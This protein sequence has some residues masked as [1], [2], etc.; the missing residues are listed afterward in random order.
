MKILLRVEHP[1]AT[2]ERVGDVEVDVA[3]THTIAELA[4][5]LASACRA[6]HLADRPPLHQQTMRLLLPEA[7]IADSGIVSGDTIALGVGLP[8]DRR[9]HELRSA[10]SDGTSHPQSTFCTGA[11]SATSGA[12]A[13]PDPVPSSDG[14]ADDLHLVVTSGVDAGL[15]YPL[16]P[17][18]HTVGRS[19]HCELTLVDPQVSRRDFRFRVTSGLG[20]DPGDGNRAD[21]SRAERGRADASGTDRVRADEGGAEGVGAGARRGSPPGNRPADVMPPPSTTPPAHPQPPP[22]DPH[23]RENRRWA[24]LAPVAVLEPGGERSNELRL[25]GHPVTEPAPLRPGDDLQVGCT[26]LQIR[27]AITERR[28]V[29][30]ATSGT[31]AFERTPQFRQP[32]QVRQLGALG[33]VPTKPSPRRFQLLAVLAPLLMG[34]SMAFFFDSPRFLLFAVLSPVV[35]IGNTIDSRRNGAKDHERKVAELRARIETRR[36]ELRAHLADEREL[37]HRAA[38]DVMELAHQA[39]THDKRLWNRARRSPD[40]L[41]LRVGLGTVTPELDIKAEGQGD[42]DL[43]LEIADAVAEFDRLVDVPVTVHLPEAGVVGAVGATTETARFAGGLAL[44]AACLHSPEDLVI[45]SAIPHERGVNEWLKWLPHTRSK[46]SPIGEAHLAGDPDAAATLIRAVSRVAETRSMIADQKLD[47]R[48]PWVLLLVDRSLEPDPAI[49]ARLLDLGASVGVSV[50]W[51]AESDRFVPRQAEVVARLRTPGEGVP[52]SLSYVDP[53]RDAQEF[54]PVRVGTAVAERTARALAPLV[55]ATATNAAATVP[56]MVTLF[57]ALGVERIDPDWI[58]EQWLT[59]RGYALPTPVGL[60]DAGPL[61]LDLVRHG[62]HGLIGGTSGAGKSELVQSLVANLIALNSPERVNLLFID[63]KGGALSGLF[64]D[65]PHA[66]GAVTNLDAMLSLRA[67][68]SLK[69]ELD[70][71]MAL[72]EQKRVKDIAE[73]L[74]RHPAEAPASLVIVVDEFAS[75][76]RELPEFVEGIVSIAERGRSLG[77]HLLLSTQR[78]SGSIN[79]NIQQN[80]NLRMSLRML[81]AGESNNVIGTA[82]AA[83]IPGHLKGRGYARLGPGELIAFQSSWSGAPLGGEDGLRPIVVAPFTTLPETAASIPPMVAVGPSAPVDD[84]PGCSGSVTPGRAG[85]NATELDAVLD[86]VVEAASRLGMG[87]GRAPWLETLPNLVPLDT[88]LADPRSAAVS[89][90]SVT[91]GMVD[92]PEAQDQYPANIDLDDGGGLAVYGSGGSGKTTTLLT[93]VCS[94]A[95]RDSQAGG[96]QLTIFGIDFASRQLG[97]LQQLPQCE[98][99]ANGDDLE[100]VTRIIATVTRLFAERQAVAADAAARNEPA[101][102]ETPVLLVI[103]G[104]DA[105][106]ETFSSAGNV[107]ALLPWFDRIVNLITQGRQVGIHCLLATGSQSGPSA[108]LMNTISNRITLR[109]TDDTAYRSFGVPSAIAT[110]LEL[111][112]GQALTRTGTGLQIAVVGH[113]PGPDGESIVDPAAVGELADG[114]VGSVLPAC[115]TRPLPTEVTRPAS[116]TGA[117]SL[118]RVELG[119][120]DLSLEPVAVDL[121]INTLCVLGPPRSGRSTSLLNAGVQLAAAGAEV[122]AFGPHGSRLDR[123]HAWS[124]AAFGK[125]AEVTALME[126]LTS[127]AEQFPDAVRYLLF[128][129][130]DRFDDMSLNAPFKALL[131]TGVRICG[132]AATSRNLIGSNPIHKELKSARNLLVLKAEDDGAIQ[133]A[134]GGRYPIRPGLAMAPGRGV[135]VSDGVATVIQGFAPQP[136]D[137]VDGDSQPVTNEQHRRKQGAKS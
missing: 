89:A 102:A 34:C 135:L 53:E 69:A 44:Q 113:R 84:N 7:T 39:A 10:G 93:A 13:L 31:V 4:V 81:D 1:T 12:G 103:D 51:L 3:P 74:E 14:G 71:R 108:R 66:V 75:L 25:N 122:W 91:I 114:L 8:D 58:A 48:W 97:V 95:I 68:T 55:D 9:R 124:G 64:S 79:E 99:V 92:N 23:S 6:P 24:A 47:P 42:D 49:T 117:P 5:A 11:G 60:T 78:P 36:N 110:G 98:V 32:I 77:I 40:F 22:P 111:A 85:S 46:N 65:V 2:G 136:S 59:D 70:R 107:T 129:D 61:T 121:E 101:T 29:S 20:I 54:E 15:S 57:E 18:T 16:V 133:A 56:S 106:A 94:A 43:I 90:S 80:T 41:E 35:A 131:E 96:G 115:T 86:A 76:V 118:A 19:R 123:H 30:L 67:L 127:A 130:V 112:P 137:R 88:V 126:Q 116:P 134:V 132:S 125:T 63:Y 17:G 104:Y 52:S 50:V 33:R 83:T 45:A 28:P 38:P 105:L 62:P 109:Q 27:T 72:F 128:D 120:A 73:M 82:D 119:I 87:R 26:T 100:A 37:R 21:V